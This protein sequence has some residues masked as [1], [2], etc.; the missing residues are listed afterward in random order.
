MTQ[1]KGP[2]ASITT[3]I[4]RKEGT[5]FQ[6]R[7]LQLNLDNINR[8]PHGKYPDRKK[9]SGNIPARESNSQPFCIHGG[10]LHVR[11]RSWVRVP[12][13]YG[14]FPYFFCRGICHAGVDLCCLS[15]IAT[16][17]VGILFLLSY[18]W[19]S[20]DHCIE[21]SISNVF[22]CSWTGCMTPFSTQLVYTHE[23]MPARLSSTTVRKPSWEKMVNF[24]NK[25]HRPKW[26]WLGISQNYFISDGSPSLKCTKKS[27][28]ALGDL[29][30]GDIT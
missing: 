13:R 27:A 14:I 8:L 1:H 23:P 7:V 28:E 2:D 11:T 12:R 10:C 29:E 30:L 5:V 22:I 25:L 26:R 24:V 20:V 9:K 18:I 15:L 21:Q 19:Y 4:Y 17:W 16:F 3:C 6:P